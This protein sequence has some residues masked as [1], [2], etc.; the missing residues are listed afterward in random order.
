VRAFKID[1]VT[2]YHTDIRFYVAAFWF[3][4]NEK[5]FNSLPPDVRK[6]IDDVSGEKLVNQMGGWWNKWDKAGRAA[7]EARNNTI[8]VPP[9]AER[10]RWAEALSG[11]YNKQIIELEGQGI[12]NARDIFLEMQRTSAKYRPKA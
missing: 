10:K 6:V 8:V 12:K 2:K 1:E 9:E 4:M 11:V 7:A 3:A 5:K